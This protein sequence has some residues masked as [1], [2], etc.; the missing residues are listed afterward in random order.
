MQDWKP[1]K[2]ETIKDNFSD[3]TIYLWVIK[4]KKD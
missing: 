4:E 3:H 2:E 1:D